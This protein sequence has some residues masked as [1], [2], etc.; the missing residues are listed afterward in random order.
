MSMCGCLSRALSWG[1][2]LQPKACAL[3][4]NQTGDPLVGR[5]TLNPLSHTSRAN[6]LFDEVSKIKIVRIPSFSAIQ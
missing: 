6:F 5:Q 2:G 3:T 1:P 4:G